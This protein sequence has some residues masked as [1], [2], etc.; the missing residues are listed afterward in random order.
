MEATPIRQRGEML[1][2]IRA[3]LGQL[4]AMAEADNCDMLAFLIEMAYLE[5]SDIL[6][7]EASTFEE[8]QRDSAA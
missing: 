7:A 3:M 4:R 2:Y 6:A 8:R 1:D 5:A